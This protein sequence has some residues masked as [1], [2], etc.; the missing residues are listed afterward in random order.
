MLNSP[1]FSGLCQPRPIYIKGLIPS[2]AH[3]SAPGKS[4]RRLFLVCKDCLVRGKVLPGSALAAAQAEPGCPS[5]TV[6]ICRGFSTSPYPA[7]PHPKPIVGLDPPFPKLLL[8]NVKFVQFFFPVNRGA[9]GVVSRE[10]R[11]KLD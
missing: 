7:L 3:F 4:P 10:L 2:P 11:R 1:V 8:F 6:G 9:R 5:L